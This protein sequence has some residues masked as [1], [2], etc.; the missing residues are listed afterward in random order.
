[1]FACP[2][3][4]SSQHVPGHHKRYKRLPDQHLSPVTDSLTAEY[5]LDKAR[6]RVAPITPGTQL[7]KDGLILG[8]DLTQG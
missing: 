8:Y 2:R 4:R 7:R 6:P 1:M 5:G 3:P